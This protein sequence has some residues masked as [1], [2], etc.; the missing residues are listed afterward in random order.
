MH[1][2]YVLCTPDTKKVLCLDKKEKEVKLI[3]IKSVKDL[4]KSLCL[5]NLTSIKSIY[6]KLKERDLVQDLDIVNIAKL[7]N[8]YT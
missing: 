5:A 8:Q 6:Q 4:N 1:T 2:G 3:E 7:Y